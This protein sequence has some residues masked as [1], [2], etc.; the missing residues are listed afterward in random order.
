MK[1]KEANFYEAPLPCSQYGFIN[2][3]PCYQYSKN[4]PRGGHGKIYSHIYYST[5]PP[6]YLL[7]PSDR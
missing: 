7:L 4:A 5:T 3:S 6:G 2:N 1:G